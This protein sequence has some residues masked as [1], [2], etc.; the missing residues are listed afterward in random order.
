[1]SGWV[2]AVD[3]GTSGLKVGAVAST[4]E[5]LDGRSSAVHTDFRTDGA[6]EQDPET[7]WTGIRDAVHGILADGVVAAGDLV[8]VGI[9][10]QYASTVPVDGSGTAVGP[11]LIWADDRGG[12]W[13]AEA[14]GG[15]AA[16]YRPSVIVPWLRYTGGAPSPGGADPSGHAL[17]LRNS[18]PEV[19]AAT[20]T[21]LEPVDYLGLRLTGRAAATP[22]SM[23]ASW[24]TDNRPGA[25]LGYAPSLVRRARRD[26]EKLPPLL[27]AGSVL[28]G[29]SASAAADL[30]LPAGTPVACGIPD[31]HSA[32]VAS[33]TI[34]DYEAHVTIGTTSWVSC[35]VP[36]KKTDIWHQIA[37][38]PGVQPDHYLVINNHET[39][40]VCLQWARDAWVG[41]ADGVG[42]A[43]SPSYEEMFAL[44]AQA[45][46]GAGGV[47]FTPWLKGER[48]PVDDRHLRGGFLNVSIGT[49]R[50]HLVRAVLEGVAHNLRW[51]VE[52]ADHFAGRRLEPLRILG[53]G[54]RSDLWCQ[55]HADI[56]DRTI[57]RVAE[58][59]RAQLRGVALY[60]LLC[61]DRIGLD[62]VPALVPVDRTFEPDPATRAVHERQYA[63]F[64]RLYGRLK[65]TYRR[66]NS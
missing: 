42:P 28:G 56:L 45:P 8:A 54:A 52:A 24:L 34:D 2:L 40:G 15:F 27:P 3:L 49:D 62:D 22:S 26:P 33:G 55:I 48:S 58:P 19:Y 29:I 66:L 12:P 63:E 31:L 39:A 44:A 41:H 38:I 10:G 16:G 9:T 5:V 51:L 32:Y 59:D 57:E 17:F 47:I 53:G 35:A 64:A 20:A 11:C 43:W 14:F 30:G 60:A 25:A 37:S 6:A 61:L 21:L 46:A 36:H 65:G 23:V 50:T 7:W 18:R 13:S 4:G 1:M